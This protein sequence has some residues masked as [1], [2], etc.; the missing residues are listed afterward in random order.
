MFSRINLGYIHGI[1]DHFFIGLSGGIGVDIYNNYED[2]Q[3]YDLRTELYY[4][5]SK[6]ATVKS[7]ISFEYFYVWHHEIMR[8]AAYS[9][10]GEEVEYDKVDYERTRFGFNFK[11]GIFVPVGERLGF[12]FFLGIGRATVNETFYDVEE[13][14]T[15]RSMP[16]FFSMYGSY[17]GIDSYF[18]FSTGV[19]LYYAF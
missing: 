19:K 14:T 4:V 2:Y 1:T 18:N 17:E 11:T 16:S 8:N 6:K 9:S 13:A 3:L 15:Y 5:F 10:G 7:Y 12:D